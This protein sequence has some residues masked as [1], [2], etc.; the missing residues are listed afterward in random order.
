MFLYTY[1]YIHAHTAFCVLFSTDNVSEVEKK[2]RSLEI[3]HDSYDTSA[4]M[5]SS[6]TENIKPASSPSNA[7]SQCQCSKPPPPPPFPENLTHY[8]FLN[9]SSVI[10]ECKRRGYFNIA[11]KDM[12]GFQAMSSEF[13]NEIDFAVKSVRQKSSTDTVFKAYHFIHVLSIFI[14]FCGRNLL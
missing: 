13:V 8:I 4:F 7:S 9:S 10:A 14:T 2:T 11:S 1:I 3:R 5:T 6:S 12:E